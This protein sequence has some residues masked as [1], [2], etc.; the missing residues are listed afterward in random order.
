MVQDPLVSV[1]TMPFKYLDVW[2]GRSLRSHEYWEH[3]LENIKNKLAGWKCNS[4]NGVGW[5]TL[6]RSTLNGIP[7]YWFNIHKLPTIVCN[8]LAM[9]RRNFLQGEVGEDEASQRKLHLVKCCKI[10]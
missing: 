1:S 10:C 6:I 4:L 9:I 2:I 3:L 5:L 8:K 7:A